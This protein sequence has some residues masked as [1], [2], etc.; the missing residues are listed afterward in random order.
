MTIQNH[1][2]I[3]MT[4][5]KHEAIDTNQEEELVVRRLL[6]NMIQDERWEPTELGSRILKADRRLHQ[7]R[8]FIWPFG[9]D[10]EPDD[11]V[12]PMH[13]RSD[14]VAVW[15]CECGYRICR[16]CFE[17]QSRHYAISVVDER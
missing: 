2:A 9:K 7:H 13:M 3:D 16:E 12:D 15:R 8:L 6:S 1:E 5:Q 17:V 11:C 4:T 10:G 14:G